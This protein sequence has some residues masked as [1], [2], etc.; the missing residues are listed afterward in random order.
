MVLDSFG[1]FA[2]QMA[3]TARA[4]FDEHR[5][6]APV[7]PGKRG[8]AFCPYSPDAGPYVMLN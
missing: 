1:D 2:P 3:D 8:G 6:D 4:F 7:C 5:I